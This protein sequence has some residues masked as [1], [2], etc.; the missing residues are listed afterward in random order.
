MKM[1]APEGTMI[2]EGIQHTF[3]CSSNSKSVHALMSMTMVMTEF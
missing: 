1:L 2:S 3:I